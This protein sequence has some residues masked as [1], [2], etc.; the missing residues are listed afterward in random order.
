MRKI[1]G[2]LVFLALISLPITKTLA[3]SPDDGIVCIQPGDPSTVPEPQSSPPEPGTAYSI[4]LPRGA[5]PLADPYQIYVTLPDTHSLLAPITNINIY[6]TGYYDFIFY[7]YITN[8][9]YKW[10]C[11]VA[12]P[13]FSATPYTSLQDQ[14]IPA[15]YGY[16][17]NDYIASL[18]SNVTWSAQ[19]VWAWTVEIKFTV[20]SLPSQ[21]NLYLS[22]NQMWT[23]LN[24]DRRVNI[25]D[26]AIVA[27]HYGTIYQ[28]GDSHVT[29]AWNIVRDNLINIV[30]IAAVAHEFGR[31]IPP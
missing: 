30:D 12:L 27:Q 1:I 10:A 22:F 29:D 3:E 25:L 31:T 8:P 13:E 7:Y 28:D 21:I 19:N 6:S 15:S 18:H 14:K 4:A 17:P 20:V 16:P 5:N 24:S 26:I 11:A 2:A 9:S 23:D